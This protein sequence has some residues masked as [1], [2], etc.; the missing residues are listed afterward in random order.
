MQKIRRDKMLGKNIRAYRINARLTQEQTTAHVQV[1]GLKLSRETYAKIESGIANIR[2][3]ELVA[4]AHIFG[5]EVG[6]FFE[7]IRPP[8]A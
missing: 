3:D 6:N 4:L 2:A 7:G 8:Q 1:V 5:A